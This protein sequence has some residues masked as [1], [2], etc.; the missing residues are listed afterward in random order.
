[1]KSMQGNRVS[2]SGWSACGDSDQLATAQRCAPLP[3]APPPTFPHE[4]GEV[5]Q[6]RP[7]PG[8]RFSS[9]LR[10][11]S[12]AASGS[13]WALLTVV[14]L[15]GL[16]VSSRAEAFGP[17]ARVASPPAAPAAPPAPAPP[18]ATASNPTAPSPP[19][20]GGSAVTGPSTPPTAARLAEARLH[21][22]QGVALFKEQN[23]DAA[24]AEFLGAYGISG[25]PVVL[26]NMALTFKAL[27][28]YSEA[29][30]ILERYL[31]ESAGHGHPVARE[32][33]AEVESIIAE[34]RS[35]L[36][37]V[38]IMLT[39]ADA[40]L[41]IDGRPTS[42]D[43]QGIV[44]LPAG[45]HVIEA[46]APDHVAGRREI[47]VVAGTAQTVALDL[48]AIPHSG[49]VTITASQ[50]GARV[51]VDGNDM[52]PAPVT[53]ELAT[54]GHQVEVMAPG[55]APS[56]SELAVAAGQS[57]TVTIVLELPPVAETAPFYHRWW[58]WAGVGVA[59][60]ATV[61]TILLLPERKQGPLS[62]TLGIA[63]TTVTTP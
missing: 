49:H 37:D 51:A 36:A 52:G 16:I 44:K 57:R 54:G 59:A 29:M 15:G 11:D 21:F 45:S 34:M 32:R 22:Q 14:G 2:A 53:I 50:I 1:M 48:D 46:G 39:P 12:S 8:H 24:L 27:F 7:K 31:A 10:G 3:A 9:C 56:R 4:R 41:R 43:V 42:L 18:A 38:T 5:N 58:F 26:Y 23:Y 30:D 28:R 35:L 33:R 20:A 17:P 19:L 63:D 61:G 40:A 13:R 55:F 60:A 6:K 62:G 47:T 25:E